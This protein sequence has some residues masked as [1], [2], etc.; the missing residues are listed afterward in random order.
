VIKIRKIYFLALILGLAG[1][2]IDNYS[3]NYI[4]L[5]SPKDINTIDALG[6]FNIYLHSGSGPDKI[7]LKGTQ[8]YL[9]MMNVKFRDHAVILRQLSSPG[10][11]DVHVYARDL[12]SLT[13][14]GNGLLSG[15]NLRIKRLKLD[16]SGNSQ[17][18]LN[19]DIRNLYSLTLSGKLKTTING[20]NSKALTVD[21]SDD[22]HTKI[23]GFINKADLM[24]KDKA[25]L[26][27]YWL[28]ASKVVVKEQDSASLQLAGKT[29]LL[30]ANIDHQA[31]FNARYLRAMK[32]FV[33]TAKSS[34]AHISSLGVQHTK[35][36]DE[37]NIYYYNDP[38]VATG[39]LR[40]EGTVLY[41][42]H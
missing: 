19:G 20:V 14:Y 29:D 39:D 17:V 9:S 21:L 2:A 23:T 31:L 16:I 5:L 3:Q 11:V 12:T 32:S 22:T 1:C 42:P 7:V 10:F 40:Q 6:N 36:L 34:L 35:A 27:L 33:T 8:Y 25:F 28:N 37:S 30:I 41:F 15:D 38:A 24:L 26:S 4:T 13:Y 18:R